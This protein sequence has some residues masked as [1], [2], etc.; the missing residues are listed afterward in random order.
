M[1]YID[2]KGRIIE[3]EDL[4][5][6]ALSLTTVEETEYMSDDEIIEYWMAK[7]E[8][9]EYEEEEEEDPDKYYWDYVNHEISVRRGK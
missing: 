1:R 7:Y 2:K 9:K 4:L 8:V 5:D 3:E 6:E